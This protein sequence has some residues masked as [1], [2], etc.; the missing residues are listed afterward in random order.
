ML[1]DLPNA[2]NIIIIANKVIIVLRNGRNI[3]LELLSFSPIFVAE[4]LLELNRNISIY[5]TNNTIYLTRRLP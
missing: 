3:E 5:F 4:S 2:S 1:G